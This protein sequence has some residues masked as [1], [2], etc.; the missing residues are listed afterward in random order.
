M[1]RDATLVYLRLVERLYPLG[2]TLKDV[3]PWNLLFDFSH[4]VYVDLT[5]VTALDAGLP[6]PEK[7]ARYYLRPLLLMQQGGERLARYLLF[8]YEAVQEQDLVLLG[9]DAGADDVRAASVSRGR[10]RSLLASFRGRPRHDPA[11]PGEWRRIVES[12]T[13]PD[14]AAA[15]PRRRDATGDAITTMID[16]LRPASVLILGAD[17]ARVA[18]P[19]ASTG[20]AVV[21]LEEDSRAVTGLY[22]RAGDTGE[23]MLPLA[24]DFSRATP[25]I[26]F[27][28]HY[29]IAASERLRC[30]LLVARAAAIDALVR[31][32]SLRPDQLAEGFAQFAGHWLVVEVV[33]DGRLEKALHNRFHVLERVPVAGGGTVVLLQRRGG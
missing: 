32:R 11:L 12:V 19:A 23:R 4:P 31:R 13:L 3:H 6:Q 27:S 33:D 26:G 15:T 21:V 20:A 24:I 16:R 17:A 9:V 22:R 2:L 30:D 8:D 10:V 14:D 29:S 5:S 25:S 28:S 18:S 1:F 7:I